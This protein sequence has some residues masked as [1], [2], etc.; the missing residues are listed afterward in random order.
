ML[1]SQLECVACGNNWYASRDDAA[2]LTIEGPN[3]GKTVGTAPLATAK[4]EDIE[5][6][7]VSPRGA[8]KG[9]NDALKKTTEA[10]VPILDNQKS[11]K[12]TRTEEDPAT[13]KA[14]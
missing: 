9:S 1:H 7:L 2:S 6:K 5:K 8:E 13:S 12:E 14:K 11:F 10:H 4:F 3:S